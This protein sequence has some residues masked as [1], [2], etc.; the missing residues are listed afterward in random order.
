MSFEDKGKYIHILCLMHQQ[1]RLDEETIRF[2][3]GSVSVKLKNK[4]KVDENGFWYNP[5]LEEETKK[6]NHF[7]QTRRDNGSKGGRP[8][9]P[10]TDRLVV[11]LATENHSGSH[12]GNENEDN[13]SNYTN[14]LESSLVVEMVN[15]F[16][17]LNPNYSINPKDHYPHCLQIAY[18]IAALKKWQPQEVLNGKMSE[19]IKSWKKIV[20]FI[21]TD[22]WLATR[23]LMDLNNTKEWDRLIMKMSKPKKDENKQ[24]KITLR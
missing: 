5:R 3:V 6:R 8:K 11:G 18:R 21:K 19:T 17:S 20:E 1:G 10:K 9:K 2:T 24:P 15:V 13:N 16:K 22:D 7:T 14:T 23:G 4:F 12:M